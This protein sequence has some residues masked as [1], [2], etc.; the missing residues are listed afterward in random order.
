MV[1]TNPEHLWESVTSTCCCIWN[2]SRGSLL[3]VAVTVS[4]E[5]TGVGGS[6]AQ[7]RQ[8]HQN[9]RRRTQRKLLRSLKRDYTINVKPRLYQNSLPVG[10]PLTRNVVPTSLNIAG[11]TVPASCMRTPHL[12]QFQGKP[13]FFVGYG[14]EV[15]T[16]SRECGVGLRS[17]VQFSPGDPITEYEVWLSPLMLC[18]ARHCSTSNPMIGESNFPNPHFWLIPGNRSHA[19]RSNEY[20]WRSKRTNSR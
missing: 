1:I 12:T 2:T 19:E 11:R 15:C 8:S 5:S 3:K 16:E 14:L 10:R 18:H 9:R 4:Q 13:L 20:T 6:G 7:R 17:L